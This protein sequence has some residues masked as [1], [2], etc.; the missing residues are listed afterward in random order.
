MYRLLTKKEDIQSQVLGRAINEFYNHRVHHTE[1]ST[2]VLIFVSV[3]ERQAIVLADKSIDEKVTDDT[4]N[5]AVETLIFGIK[6]KN[7]LEG[8]QKSIQHIEKVLEEYFPI[9]DDDQNE[10]SNHLIIQE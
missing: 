2:G 7:M 5:K 4:W 3:W 9:E 8:F 6:R 1:K 10:I